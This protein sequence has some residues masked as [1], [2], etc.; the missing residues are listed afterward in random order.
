M[1]HRLLVPLAVRLAAGDPSLD[2]LVLDD[3][4]LLEVDEEQLA[5]GQPPL[6]LDVLGG[7]GHHAGLGGE[8]DVSLRVLHPAARA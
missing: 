5:R 6:A 4:P 2:L 8:H 3:P 7:D 1:H